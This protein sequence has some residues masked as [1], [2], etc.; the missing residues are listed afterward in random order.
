MKNKAQRNVLSPFGI[1]CTDWTVQE[2]SLAIKRIVENGGKLPDGVT[3][4]N[5]KDVIDNDYEL[6][7]PVYTEDGK[8]N[9]FSREIVPESL[10]DMEGTW[11]VVDSVEYDGRMLFELEN[12]NYGYTEKEI[13][14]SVFRSENGHMIVDEDGNILFKNTTND[15]LLNTE[16][17]T[18]SEC[19]KIMVDGYFVDG[20]CD[21]EYY[22]SDE[23]LHKH[24]TDEEFTDLYEEDLAYWT[25]W[26]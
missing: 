10:E 9:Q 26:Y 14:P 15:F 24:Y 6:D 1:D 18:C 4:E 2:A 13:A 22:C 7:H 20:A 5:F 16:F 19:G 17:R 25:Q 12:D 11:T 21:Y 3:K 23:C 8:I